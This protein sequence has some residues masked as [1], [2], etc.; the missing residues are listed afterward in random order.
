M[1]QPYPVPPVAPKKGMSVGLIILIVVLVTIIPI[2]GILAVLGVYGTRRYIANAKTAEA[3]NSLA[4]IAKGA[5]TA[6]EESGKDRHL[7][8]SAS[9]PVP[10]ARSDVSGKKYQSSRGDWMTD[11]AKNAGFACLK[12]EMISPQYFQYEYQAT[13]TGFVARAHGDLNGD[14]VFSTFEITGQLVG[15]RLVISPSILETNP[16]E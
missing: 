10:A 5:V 8:S 9:A 6:F 15:D 2:V 7:C 11:S 3:K 16:D 4:Y 14:G 12:F 13:A 1:Q